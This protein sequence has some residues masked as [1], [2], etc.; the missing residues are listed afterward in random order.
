MNRPEMKPQA[1]YVQSYVIGPS[2]LILRGLLPCDLV[3]SHSKLESAL[4][5]IS[6]LCVDTL[7]YRTGWWNGLGDPMLLHP[8]DWLTTKLAEANQF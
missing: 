3:E 4:Y 8:M 1:C 6:E 5:G 2:L 7:S